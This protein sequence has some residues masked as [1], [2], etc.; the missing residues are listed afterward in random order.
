MIWLVIAMAKA[1]AGLVAWLFAFSQSQR[2]AA[3]LSPVF[4]AMLLLA[5]TTSGIGLVAGSRRGAPARSLGTVFCL[6]GSIFAD[7]LLASPALTSSTWLMTRR[8]LYAAVPVV[9]VPAFFW[10]FAWDFPRRQPALVPPWLPLQF[11]R[12]MFAAGGIL[13]GALVFV[14]AGLVPDASVADRVRDVSWTTVVV[15]Q[16]PTVALLIAKV[17]TALPDERRRVRLFI[18]GIVLGMAPLAGDILLSAF[19]PPYKEFFADKERNRIVAAVIASAV[20]V[21]P[22]VT[23]YAV[24]VDRVLET[25]F[26]VRLAVQYAFARYTVLT[27]MAVP[28]AFLGRHFY[29]QRHRSLIEILAEAPPQ[30]WL[31]VLGLTLCLARVRRPVL[32]AI[33]RRYFREQHDARQILASLTD[34]TRRAASLEQL[35]RLVVLEIDKALHVQ[36]VSVLV[37]HGDQYDDPLGLT[38]TLH[39][40]GTLTTLVGG[41]ASALVVDLSDDVSPLRRLPK[42]ELEWI[43]AARARLLLPLIGSGDEL[44]GLLV[45]GEKRS[46][47]RYS[48]EDRVLLQ[49]V[50]NSAALALEQ[51]L[52]STPGGPHH[53][54]PV[55]ESS[56]ES[57]PARQCDACDRLFEA[58]ASQ[59]DSCGL[60]LRNASIPVV[61]AGKFRVGR[62]LGSGGMGIVYRAHDITLNRPVAIKTLPKLSDAAAR[63]LRRE[64][65]ALATLHHPHLEGIYG[66]ESWRGIPMLV[67]E[68]LSGGTLA[69]RLEAGPL[70]FAEAVSIGTAMADALHSL[71]RAGV[72]HRDIKPSNIGFT[73]NGVV[74]LLDFGLAVI[75]VPEVPEAQGTPHSV[76]HGQSTTRTQ[77]ESPAIGDPTTGF[78]VGTPLYMSPEAIAGSAPDVSFDLWGLSVTL[79]EAV[80]GRN[81]FVAANRF[82]TAR[83]IS[84]GTLPEI[85]SLRANCPDALAAFLHD[86]LSLDR[87]RRPPSAREFGVRLRGAGGVA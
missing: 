85:R 60:P 68:Y 36:G 10:R 74:K 57:E 6:F 52:R 47:T 5:F 20:L 4:H 72:L 29:L 87:R 53:A 81:P 84:S 45:L 77:L 82:E 75:T 28:I 31:A 80:A 67:L 44:L 30:V 83:L 64:A 12:L 58:A 35:S 56:H 15:L 16:L 14:R 2:P 55:S 19:V 59:C 71:H 13:F 38:P 8:L 22:F 70:D 62:R 42:A 46:E 37:R 43:E 66:V 23:A 79:F 33:D 17:R 24:V 39:A 54:E 63:R 65:R 86:S 73:E 41:S 26:I 48:N 34:S 32:L 49:A 51:Q 25:R 27:L 50:A 9:M 69:K 76:Q 1:T 61:L 18:S 11:E 78:L 7:L 3:V 40:S 21:L